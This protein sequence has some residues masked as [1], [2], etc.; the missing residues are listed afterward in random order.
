[1]PAARRT[2]RAMWSGMRSVLK[3]SRP[4][5]SMTGSMVRVAKAKR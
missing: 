5:A 1:M 4:E 3:D 2:L